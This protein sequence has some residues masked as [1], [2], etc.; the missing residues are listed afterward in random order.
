M[1]NLKN[2]F[3]FFYLFVSCHK[4]KSTK[5]LNNYEQCKN[6]YGSERR[7]QSGM[8]GLYWGSR[9]ANWPS[10]SRHSRLIGR[11]A[12]A[13]TTRKYAENANVQWRNGGMDD[14]AGD[15]LGIGP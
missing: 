10:V 9:L 7:K 3:F 6:G 2:K 4:K 14:W 11:R 5:V 1:P 12:S 8:P 15:G 13:T